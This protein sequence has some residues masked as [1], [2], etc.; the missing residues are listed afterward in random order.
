MSDEIGHIKK[1]EF[2]SLSSDFGEL[3]K[4]I[5][6][7]TLNISNKV[8]NTKVSEGLRLK[9][10]KRMKIRRGKKEGVTLRTQKQ[11]VLL[12]GSPCSYACSCTAGYSSSWF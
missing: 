2:R 8:L 3:S 1:F 11:L 10:G 12:S 6:R 7:I 4:K 9:K 5:V